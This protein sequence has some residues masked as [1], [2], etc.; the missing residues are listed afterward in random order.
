LVVA[1][2]T[3][4]SNATTSEYGPEAAIEQLGLRKI[5]VRLTVSGS[6][7]NGTACSRLTVPVR[8]FLDRAYDHSSSW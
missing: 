1:F 6:Q 8:Q 7:S 4:S 5:A 2:S 3:A